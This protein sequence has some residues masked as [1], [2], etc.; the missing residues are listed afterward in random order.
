VAQAIV[1]VLAA[2]LCPPG[3]ATTDQ[4]TYRE[5]LA[6]T[7]T[8]GKPLFSLF[9]HPSAR[10]RVYT[11]RMMQAIAEEGSGAAAMLRA[12]A[13]R[14][15]AVLHHLNISVLPKESDRRQL[16]RSLVE[17]WCMGY[18][19]SLQLL[20]RVLPPGLFCLVETSQAGRRSSEAEGTV[21]RWPAF[22]H[23]LDSNHAKA[24]LIWD[25][26]MRAALR[27]ALDR[28]EASLLRARV[29]IAETGGQLGWNHS[30]F[31]V[32]YP[33]L[34]RELV[35]GDV[36]LRLLLEDLATEATSALRDLPDPARFF[37]ALHREFLYLADTSVETGSYSGFE[38]SLG[39]GPGAAEGKRALCL[40]AMSAVY[41]LHGSTIGPIGGLGHLVRLMDTTKSVL[42][43]DRLLQLLEAAIC[44]LEGHAEGGEEGSELV[45][46]DAKSRAAWQ[47]A[48]KANARQLVL[49]DGVQICVELLA[50]VHAS[51]ER[52]SSAPVRGNLLL[53]DASHAE[54]LKVWYVQP[55]E[56][57]SGDVTAPPFG[58]EGPLTK[59][60][61]RHKHAK[62]LLGDQ[63]LVWTQG[64]E[65]PEPLDSLR[66]LRWAVG[67][68]RTAKCLTVAQ[69]AHGALRVLTTLASLHAAHD[70]DGRAIEPLPLVHRQLARPSALPHVAQALLCG[71]PAVVPGAAKLMRIVLEHHHEAL[72]T[73]F[74]T[75]AFFFALMYTG[76]NFLEISRLLHVA[77][78]KQ[79]F[80]SAAEVKTGLRLSGRSFLGG[81]LP[82]ALLHV[83]EQQGPEAF[84]EVF[85]ADRNT[86]EVVW[87]HQMRFTRLL[88]QMLAH[89]GDTSKVLEQHNRAVYEYTPVPPVGY[90]ELDTEVWCHRY[91]L[92]NLCDVETFPR[93]PIAEHV[94]LLQ[95]I[96][97]MW[98]EE[99]TREPDAMTLEAAYRAMELE[100]GG[101][102]PTEA[103]LKKA[104]RRLAR[105]YHPDKS[106]E[107]GAQEKF[108][109]VQQAFEWLT[110]RAGKEEDADAV[111]CDGPRPWRLLLFVKAQC[112]LFAR[113]GRELAP[114]KYAGYPLLLS[115]IESAQTD[116]QVL[117]WPASD[118]LEKQVL[119]CWLTCVSSHLNGEELFRCSGLDILSQ[120]LRKCL[121]QRT[122][123]CGPLDPP[124]AVA[125]YVLRTMAGL[126]ALPTVQGEFRGFKGVLVRDI[127]DACLIQNAPA[128]VEAAL[129]CCLSLAGA[130]P[131]IQRRL[132]KAGILWKLLPLLLTFDTT[133][134]G[135]TA[136]GRPAESE[137]EGAGGSS[138]EE[139]SRDE[140][141][142]ML[143]RG[144]LVQAN[145]AKAHNLHTSFAART[146][147][148]MGGYFSASSQGQPHEVA[149]WA[150]H[151]LLTPPFAR[152]LAEVDPRALLC[153]LGSSME[154]P[155]VIWNQDMRNEL[156]SVCDDYAGAL[157][158]PGV[159]DEEDFERDIEAI[160][161]SEAEE[162]GFWR[163]FV[164]ER[165]RNEFVVGG[166][167]VRVFNEM[168]TSPLSD[169]AAFAVKLV[170]YLEACDAAPLVNQPPG[171]DPQT[172]DFLRMCACLEAIENLLRAVPKLSA[173]F[174]DVA[175]ISPLVKCLEPIE[176]LRGA[177]AHFRRRRVLLKSL[178][179]LNLVAGHAAAAEVLA[180]EGLLSRCFWLLVDAA[181]AVQEDSQREGLEEQVEVFQPYE[182]CGMLTLQLLQALSKTNTCAWAAGC[183]GG[184]LY[185]LALL[186]PAVHELP[187][188]AA[189]R[190]EIAPEDKLW[191][192]LPPPEQA[193]CAGLLGQLMGQVAHGNRVTLLCNILLPPGMTDALR[194][195]NGEEVAQGFRD[196]RADTPER[197]WT[198]GM[199]ERTG[200]AV[201]RLAR[202]ALKQQRAGR[203]DL[204]LKPGA[205]NLVHPE[206]EGEVIV[207]GVFVKRFL[208]EP[209]F[210]LRAPKRFLECVM[211]GVA[212]ESQQCLE[213]LK[214]KGGKE[215]GS[216]DQAVPAEA[217]KVAM[218]CSAAAALLRV[219]PL[220]TDHAL[221][222]AAPAKLCSLLAAWVPFATGAA[223][224]GP[225]VVLLLLLQ[226]LHVLVSN[227]AVSQN[228]AAERTQ[229][230]TGP[231]RAGEGFV[232]ALQ[233]MLAPPWGDAAHVLVLET[234]K[235][236]LAAENRSRGAF[237]VEVERAGLVPALLAR[238]DWRASKPSAGAEGGTPG[239]ALVASATT[240]TDVAAARV[241][242]VDI[243]RLLVRDAAPESMDPA[244]QAAE[245]I[246]GQL[247]ASDVWKAQS[248][249]RHDLF[250]PG[251]ANDSRGGGGVA[252]LL[253][254]ASA[255]APLALTSS[256]TQ[257]EGQG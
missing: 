16:S 102:P 209:E 85:V 246:R 95:Q 228:L 176:G 179:V 3:S 205:V 115:E 231:A 126:A 68:R 88:P 182:P 217:Q 117:T 15:G 234:L 79:A 78:L 66:E 41:R 75:G 143:L 125:A 101:E 64:M 242:A 67:A 5:A 51:K 38:A 112:I 32:A 159:P 86:P 233:A 37:H 245:R 207:G 186:L 42:M 18:D 119:L 214:S 19:P 146:L 141:A 46:L 181:T 247:E 219:Q 194:D 157:P 10:T 58:L 191:R 76:E 140:E 254:G 26:H 137:E 239:K 113:C 173:L 35:I 65:G 189:A 171:P 53:T 92:R 196:Y 128:C 153:D 136:E 256:D 192:G 163:T 52:G 23:A 158:E 175:M 133:A 200:Q 203:L 240:G 77:H 208:E 139:A 168:P 48:I 60:E 72:A 251:T 57:Y 122:D 212:Q 36:F 216:G 29:R 142:N 7:S 81:L 99:L 149:K 111:D 145:M 61:L 170:E 147:A 94:E 221:A 124:S 63:S 121:V 33:S 156:R 11:A 164:Y 160:Q 144:G 155:E 236:G 118:H 108:M 222:I 169:P 229:S 1:Q 188:Q 84:A 107:E 6:L 166:V 165:L 82:E 116:L 151:A 40:H 20:Q 225:R 232:R 98:R 131:A 190:A 248:T 235:R 172:D 215:E 28:E 238:L 17:L 257:N 152:R 59:E 161:S 227:T 80:H 218:L 56:D 91:Y 93:W 180:Y 197:V 193:L 73:L 223:G 134:E 241:L 103:D 100:E 110:A 148:S 12:A 89:V 185:C 211:E 237:V 71:D 83:L 132:H 97:Q 183:Q 249:Q 22:W 55:Q 226:I 74:R 21:L 39:V 167:F 45:P 44:S 150:L 49:A 127:V 252:G 14:E 204:A 120:V 96:L 220:L 244:V 31:E 69:A 123:D 187:P 224:R 201:R 243:L 47:Q 50:G 253:Q 199:A 255:S 9:A 162:A 178:S 43:R 87:T 54:P 174:A 206:L 135:S 8:L 34:E 2:V 130:E 109:Q 104:Y 129:R 154:L 114:F 27:E 230:P 184:G 4:D 198:A 30:E 210:P 106:K 90:P 62:G 105:L 202:L 177:E 213:L 250:L 25:E 138:R 13:L 195:R 70:E 24:T